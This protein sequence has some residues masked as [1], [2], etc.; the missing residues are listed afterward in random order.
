MRIL[1]QEGGIKKRYA[2][3]KTEKA[4]GESTRQIFKECTSRRESSFRI[5]QKRNSECKNPLQ[6]AEQEENELR[7]PRLNKIKIVSEALRRRVIENDD[8]VSQNRGQNKLSGMSKKLSGTGMAPIVSPLR[9]ARS[10]PRP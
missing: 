5:G 1:T 6:L 8:R 4:E 3:Y 9:H 2:R 7:I 10:L